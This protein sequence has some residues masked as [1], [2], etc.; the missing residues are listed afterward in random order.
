M[1]DLESNIP[2]TKEELLKI[3]FKVDYESK[4]NNIICLIKSVDNWS[5]EFCIKNGEISE[6]KI[7]AD[8]GYYYNGSF[9]LSRFKNIEQ[10]VNLINAMHGIINK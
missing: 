3:G 9:D 8:G 6:S 1:K 5:I 4:I 10:I 7:E 2:I